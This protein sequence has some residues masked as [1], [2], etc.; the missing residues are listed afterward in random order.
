MLLSD[1]IFFFLTLCLGVSVWILIWTW[2]DIRWPPYSQ[3]ISHVLVQSCYKI[4]LHYSHPTGPFYKGMGSVR[5]PCC[6]PPQKPS[7][8]LFFYVTDLSVINSVSLPS[9]DV[10]FHL[11]PIPINWK[12]KL[13]HFS[14]RERERGRQTERKDPCGCFSFLFKISV[15]Q[16][17]LYH[18]LFF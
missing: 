2:Q 12:W 11:S 4:P 5:T 16:L 15:T 7:G 13:R 10:Y 8:R 6:G 14:E 17:L 3:L 18:L 1:S 9:L